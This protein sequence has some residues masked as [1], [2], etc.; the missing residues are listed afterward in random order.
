MPCKVSRAPMT[1][2]S[3]RQMNKYLLNE[4]YSVAAAAANV[5]RW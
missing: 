3:I 1:I 4:T 2:K 5:A